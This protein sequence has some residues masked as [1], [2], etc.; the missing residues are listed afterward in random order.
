MCL[1]Y[2]LMIIIS[3]IIIYTLN[4]VLCKGFLY[5][6]LL[7]SLKL[8]ELGIESHGLRLNYKGQSSIK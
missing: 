1:S 4:S 3:E 5:A 7:G 8:S 2:E 6:N